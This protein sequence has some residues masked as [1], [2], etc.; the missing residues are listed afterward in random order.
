V[1][2]P[3]VQ[4]DGRSKVHATPRP[5]DAR[6][7]MP[8]MARRRPI[9][10]VLALAA[11]VTVMTI[12]AAVFALLATEFFAPEPSVPDWLMWLAAPAI[13]LVTGWAWLLRIARGASAD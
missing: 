5:I 9:R 10:L 12:A 6:S 2:D 7:T 8:S 1:I 11:C 13:L 4:M 3:D